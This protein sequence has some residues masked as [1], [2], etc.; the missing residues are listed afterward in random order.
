[1]GKL[2]DEVLRIE[3]SIAARRLDLFRMRARIGLVAGF[4]LLAIRPET[5]DDPARLLRLRAAAAQV[6][7]AASAS[8]ADAPAVA[9]VGRRRSD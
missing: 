2:Y 4:P 5:P 3:Q 8:T 7:D 1:M 9:T 6:L